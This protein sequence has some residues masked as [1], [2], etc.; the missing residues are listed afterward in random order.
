MI[1][2]KKY[3]L[4][5]KI[6]YKANY[7]FA[8]GMDNQT[9]FSDR[10]MDGIIE[11]IIKDSSPD[12]R[13]EPFSAKIIPQGKNSNSTR[14]LYYNKRYYNEQAWPKPVKPGSQNI[15][16]DDIVDDQSKY[17]GA[18]RKIFFPFH[19]IDFVHEKA[20]YGRID[21]KNQ[22]IYPSE[23]VLSLVNNTDDVFLVNFVAEACNDMQKKIEALKES[24]K[25]SKDS[26]FYEFKVKRG[27]ESFLQNHHEAM[28]S[29]YN[30]FITKYINIPAIFTK[31]TN[32]KQYSRE[33]VLFLDR[34]LPKFPITRTNMQ[35]R[36]STNPRISGIVFEIAENTHDDDK[37]K[38]TDFILDK[39]FLQIQNIANGYGFMV[40]KNAPWRF[41][42]DLE[43]PQMRARMEEKGF[44]TL[45]EMFDGYYYKT[46][47]FEVDSLRN[48]FNSFYDSFVE[49]Y[50]YYTIVEKCGDGSKAKLLYR[51][52][53][54]ENPFTDEKLLEFY[55]YIRAKEA[56][57]EW[58]QEEFDLELEEALEIFKH[59][60]QVNGKGFVPAIN[61]INDKTSNINGLGANPGIRTKKDE[62]NRIIHT[63]QSSYKRNNFTI[64][65]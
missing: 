51:Q 16:D 56:H 48:Y 34:F 43:S 54:L 12:E 19:Y 60:N 37:K 18:S 7:D 29:L 36:R 55:Y 9:P 23:K 62:N 4:K 5:E 26:I 59:Y 45:Q 61:F 44:G 25:L 31:I 52:R 65:L 47:L 15:M 58:S 38:Y 39:H 42:A 32:Y 17:Q 1:N 24:N 28:T 50:P 10:E 33:F 6:I 40:D 14:N 8:Q 57:K 21:T 30:S 46:H 35:L 11:R 53:R 13:L 20:Y 49:G 2:R 3:A 41:I 27:W 22:S 64:V 63:H